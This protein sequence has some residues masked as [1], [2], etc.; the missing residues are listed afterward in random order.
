[1]RIAMSVALT[2]H[3]LLTQKKN[4]KDI[5]ENDFYIHMESTE[6]LKAH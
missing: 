3:E 4:E 5:T 1:M 6:K 2:K